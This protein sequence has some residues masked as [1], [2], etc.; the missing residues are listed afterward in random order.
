MIA[1]L[2][3]EI[4]WLIICSRIPQSPIIKSPVNPSISNSSVPNSPSA[5][6]VRNKRNRPLFRE[7]RRED[8]GAR[9]AVHIARDGQP[10]KV[11]HGWRD[12][13]DRCAWT[14]ALGDAAAERNQEAVRCRFMAAAQVG[15]AG[16][17]LE[18]PLAEAE[19]LHTEARHHEQQIVRSERRHR[20]A[21]DAI[22]VG[23]VLLEHAAEAIALYIRNI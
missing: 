17:A 23:V 15:V 2:V 22:D 18:Q 19:R 16:H 6:V 13:H 4:Y 3:M 9:V 12:V 10:E 20:L 1:D 11:Q 21:D 8:V 7:R 14:G 5:V